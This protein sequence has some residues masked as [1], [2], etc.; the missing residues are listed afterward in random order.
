M[1]LRL[2]IIA[3]LALTAVSCMR[4]INPIGSEQEKGK[5]V[6]ISATIPP[7]TRVSYTDSDIP[8]N[9]GTLTWQTGDTLLLAGYDGTIYKG[10]N[11]FHWKGGDSFE[12]LEVTGAT[13]YKAYYPGERVTLDANGN[14]QLAGTFWQQTQSGDNST[15]HLRH[16]LLLFDE[17]AHAINQTFDLTLKSSIIRFNLDGVPADVGSLGNLIWS[18]ETTAGVTKSMALNVTG[19][20]FSAAKDNLTAF[21]SFDPAVTDIAANGRVKIT[22]RGGK[23]Y[24]WNTTVAAGKNYT[25]GN[26]YKAAVNSGWTEM[27]VTYGLTPLSF[28][29]EYNVNPA[30]DGFV[31]N[32]TACTGSGYFNWNAAQTI[33][34]AGYH[35]PSLEEWRGIV[36]PPTHIYFNNNGYTVD[37]VSETVKVNGTSYTSTN[38]YRNVGNKTY[39]LRYKGT[40]WVSAWK[41]EYISDGDNTHM[42][43]TSRGVAPSVTITNIANEAFWSSG[44]ENDVVRYFPA[45]G[46][47]NDS[48]TLYNFGNLG[49]FWSSS[50][51]SNTHA[52]SMSFGSSTAMSGSNTYRGNSLSVRLFVNDAPT[53]PTPTPL[54]YVAEYNANPAGTG[55]VTNPTACNVSGYFNWSNAVMRFNTNK[56]IPGYHLPNLKEW[57]GIVP[58]YD[59]NNDI[60]YIDFH[61]SSPYDN[62]SETV[63]VQGQSITMTSDYRNTGSPGNPAPSYALRY[64]G[65]NWVSAWK[66]E[67]ISDGNNT[68]MKITSRGVASSVT[69]S[70]V[71]DPTF[72]SSGQENDV[73]RYFPASGFESSSGSPYDVGCNG[74]FWSSTENY[75]SEAWNLAFVVNGTYMANDPI[76]TTKHTV[77]LFMGEPTL[78]PLNYVADYNVNPAGDGF[79]TFATTCD[80]SGYFTYNQATTQFITKIIDG[81]S[82]HLPSNTEWFG[83]IPQYVNNI[84][85]ISFNST[86][87][88]DGIT[89]NVS[90]HGHN[91][92]MTS[93]F[94]NPG[95]HVSYALRYK[96]TKWVSAWKYEFV[97]SLNYTHIRV[98]CRNVAPSVTIDTITENNGAFWNTDTENDVIR[99]FPASG[100]VSSGSTRQVG[101]IGH[102]WSSTN[103][104]TV[105]AW[106]IRFNNSYANSNLYYGK[107]DGFTIRLFAPGN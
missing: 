84:S 36:A 42:M 70:Q 85:Y 38:D 60:L 35:L 20:T 81:I 57:R 78:T 14:V 82:Y 80:V 59:Y 53:P 107:A 96:G 45:S 27:P 58:E 31:T 87:P 34:I 11:K 71:A 97:N 8:G 33:N 49:Y 15:A 23:S 92:T 103:N 7:D 89:E 5:M 46:Y 98:S 74:I 64:K 67:Y 51:D 106:S 56:S 1:R 99:Y 43:I 16:S 79:V 52:W 86:P 28:V 65:T 47:K 62:V 61:G 26:R 32:L 72:W 9:G 29:A 68:H 101:T 95:N 6:T 10:S 104:D 94:R 17:T 40:N 77:R 2:F 83:I 105:S 37:N 39:A 66:Y 21:L 3:L 50:L 19:V 22:L 44:N 90:V 41:Y 73:I 93:D 12:G 63:E 91:I 69:I 30:G 75:H 100:F 76:K 102:F 18:V 24:Q 55:F 25:I 54:S 13:T 48:G 88:Y 4:D